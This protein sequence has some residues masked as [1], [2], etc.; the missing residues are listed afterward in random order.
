MFT[1]QL[2]DEVFDALYFLLRQK[3]L[4]QKLDEER[5]YAPPRP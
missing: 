4:K 5:T 3:H 1:D 2:P